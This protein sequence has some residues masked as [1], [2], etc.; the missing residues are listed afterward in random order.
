MSETHANAL[1]E[2]A[3][4]RAPQE[5]ASSKE[6]RRLGKKNI[7]PNANYPYAEKMKREMY[8]VEKQHL[9]ILLL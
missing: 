7:F 4:D 2:L 8:E 3:A 1:S 6:I 9:Q 5:L